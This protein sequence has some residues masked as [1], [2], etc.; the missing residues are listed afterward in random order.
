MVEHTRKANA[1]E[2]AFAYVRRTK[3]DVRFGKFPRLRAI[4]GLTP[5][6]ENAWGT[7]WLGLEKFYWDKWGSVGTSAG[8]W[9]AWNMRAMNMSYPCCGIPHPRRP[10][11]RVCSGR[12]A[13]A[14]WKGVHQG[15]P[16]AFCIHLGAKR[17]TRPS[18]ILSLFERDIQAKSLLPTQKRKIRDASCY[19]ITQNFA[20]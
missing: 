20:R 8:G 1:L 4:N 14:Y 16:A 17:R 3:Y 11:P 5:S 18:V 9:G 15:Y 6:G 2:N 12:G 7:G 10:S 13:L 19:K